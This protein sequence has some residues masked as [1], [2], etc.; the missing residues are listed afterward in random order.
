LALR[1]AAPYL[2][3][4]LINLADKVRSHRWVRTLPLNESVQVTQLA[5]QSSSITASWAPGCQDAPI[6]LIGLPPPIV[7]VTTEGWN[8]LTDK[9][10][11]FALSLSAD[12]IAVT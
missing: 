7:L 6:S 9:A 11:A 8:R 1:Q 12:V 2:G 5:R 10:L 4:F 3:P